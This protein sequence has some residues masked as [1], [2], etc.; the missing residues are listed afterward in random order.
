MTDSRPVAED[1]EEMR[2]ILGR[3]AIGPVGSR[4]LERQGARRAMHLALQGEVSDVQI[5][6]FLL[7][8]RL[9]RETTDENLGFLDALVGASTI[10]SARSPEVVSLADPYNGFDRVPHFA[11]VTAAVLAACGLP[12]YVHGGVDVPP[13]QGITSL[14]VFEARGQVIPV[15]G[16]QATV[17]QA[18]TRLAD[19]GVAYVDVRDFCPPLAALN[20]IRRDIAK[21]PCL[22]L[23][24]KLI[25]PLRGAERTH[26]V[27][28]WV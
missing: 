1:W 5:G 9:K 12:S 22:A 20:K 25:T 8:A 15:G 27:T 23:L 11:P 10:T 14:A 19:H 3:I 16:G 21:R 28:G 13:K 4:D 18:A 7:A 2:E 24:E 26:V 17:E 6:A